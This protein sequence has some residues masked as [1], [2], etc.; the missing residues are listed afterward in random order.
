ADIPGVIARLRD[1]IRERTAERGPNRRSIERVRR[2]KPLPADLAGDVQADAAGAE[3]GAG[4][5]PLGG[6]RSVV[7]PGS[8]I[9]EVRGVVLVEPDR[10][11]VVDGDGD[12]G[13]GLVKARVL[14]GEVAVDGQTTGGRAEIEALAESGAITLECCAQRAEALPAR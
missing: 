14:L 13:I 1:T 12:L 2:S 11:L 8:E 5:G 9:E 7:A 4:S 10:P 3:G 6:D